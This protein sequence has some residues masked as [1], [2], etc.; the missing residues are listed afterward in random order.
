[1]HRIRRVTPLVAVVSCLVSACGKPST[2]SA[3][4]G[5]P[6][7]REVARALSAGGA[8]VNGPFSIVVTGDKTA[9]VSG[10][11]A[12]FCVS[13]GSTRVFALSLVERTWAVSIMAMGDRPGVGVHAMGGNITKALTADLTDKTTG[14]RPGDWVHSD[15]SSGT[16]TITRSDSAQLAGTYELIATPRGGGRWHATGTF[17]ANPTKC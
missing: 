17:A 4:Q 9:N 6:P 15:L 11:D 3:Q 10:R 13:D 8:D 1:M 2:P 12:T 7:A 16:L 5:A 14:A